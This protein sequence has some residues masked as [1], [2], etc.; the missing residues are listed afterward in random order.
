MRSFQ[1]IL[2]FMLLL[3]KCKMNILLLPFLLFYNNLSTNFTHKKAFR[4]CQCIYFAWTLFWVIDFISDHLSFFSSVASM[5]LKITKS[6][7]PHF[8]F[9]SPTPLKLVPIPARCPIFSECHRHSSSYSIVN[10]EVFLN[11][12]SPSDPISDKFCI[13]CLLN[14]SKSSL[15]SPMFT[16]IVLVQFF[17]FLMRFFILYHLHY[18]NWKETETVPAHSFIYQIFIEHPCCFRFWTKSENEIRKPTLYLLWI[19]EFSMWKLTR[20]Y[21]P[22]NIS[23]AHY[24]FGSLLIAV[25]F[26]DRHDY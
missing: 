19:L 5:Y 14:I 7:W 9:S 23:Q 20:I 25:S 16:T 21:C 8:F 2:L 6:T 24:R 17:F 3:F 22:C 12:S 18:C 4:Y 26:K 15:L 11:P 10:L 13:F 1:G